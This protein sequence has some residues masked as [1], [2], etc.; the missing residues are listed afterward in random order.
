MEGGWGS[1]TFLLPAGSSLA[2]SLANV[3][4]NIML[5]KTVKIQEIFTIHPP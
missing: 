5:Y 4:F 1:L 2:T 3:I